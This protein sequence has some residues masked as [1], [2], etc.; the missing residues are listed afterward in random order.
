MTA[1]TLHFDASP[2]LQTSREPPRFSVLRLQGVLCGPVGG[3]RERKR[4]RWSGISGIPARPA[5]YLGILAARKPF[6]QNPRRNRQKVAA[7]SS[8]GILE[9]YVSPTGVLSRPRRPPEGPGPPGCLR[10]GGASSGRAFPGRRGRD[11]GAPPGAPGPESS[12]PQ[13]GTV[14]STRTRAERY[15]VSNSMQKKPHETLLS[16]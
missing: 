4:A 7:S 14:G 13:T 8:P 1:P 12:G 15:L 2:P 11:R 5:L 6:R 10:G 9:S 3:Q 16:K